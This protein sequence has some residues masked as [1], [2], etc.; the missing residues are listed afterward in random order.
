[1]GIT[2]RGCYKG[3]YT[4]LSTVNPFDG[5][6]LFGGLNTFVD[7]NPFDGSAAWSGYKK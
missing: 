2:L 5:L 4:R 1:M 3:L 7:H 6:G